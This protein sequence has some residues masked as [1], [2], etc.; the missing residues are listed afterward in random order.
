M[1]VSETNLILS[2]FFLLSHDFLISLS[3]DPTLLGLTSTRSSEGKGKGTSSQC[4]ESGTEP[5]EAT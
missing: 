2:P 1:L 3:F 5:E 4:T